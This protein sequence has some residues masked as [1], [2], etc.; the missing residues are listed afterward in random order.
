MEIGDIYLVNF[1]PSIGNEYRKMRP[2]IVLQ[3]ASISKKS[4]CVTVMPISSKVERMGADDVLIPCNTKN[5]L[6]VDSV[7][8]VHQIS[9]FDK[10]RF[11]KKIG[12]ANSPVLRLVRGYLRRHFKL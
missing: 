6:L 5:K 12:N 10:V 8:K 4:K 2:A 11:I 1:E 7:V 9:S 3:D